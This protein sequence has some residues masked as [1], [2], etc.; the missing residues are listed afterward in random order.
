MSNNPFWD[1]QQE[2][3]KMWNENMSKLPGMEAYENVYKNFMPDAAEYWKKFFDMV[4]S[5][6]NVMQNPFTAMQNMMQNPWTAMQNPF[7]MMTNMMPS[8]DSFWK[9]M[10]AFMPNADN[11]SNLWSYQIPGLDVY[12][13]VFELWKGMGDPST[14]LPNF[15]ERYMD[16]MQDLFKGFLPA[17][18]GSFFEKPQKLM[19]TC[20][21]F[22]QHI[23]SPWMKIDENLLQRIASGDTHA[24]VEFFKEFG[25]KYEETFDKFFNMMGMGLNRE[26][27]EDQM[28][29]ISAYIKMMFSTGSMLALLTETIQNSMQDLVSRYQSEMSDGKTITTFRDFYNVWFK[30]TEDALIKLFNTDEFSRAF[31]DFSNKA[32][33]YMVASNRVTERMLRSLPIPTNTDMKSLYQTVYDLRKDVRDLRRELAASKGAKQ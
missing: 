7:S 24:Y 14:F 6:F 8:M 27:N 1:Q 5:A 33:Q 21:D 29:A 25:T 2:L 19:D 10:S 17:G 26:S 23:M 12:S 9:N 22:Y 31:G 28:Q 18:V 15:Q 11:F 4:P 30:V 32:G 3:F 16:L 20:V 13:K